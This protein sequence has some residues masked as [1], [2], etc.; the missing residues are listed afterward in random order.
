MG[1]PRILVAVSMA[2]GAIPSPAK[3][4]CAPRREGGKLGRKPKLTPHQRQEALARREAGEPLA[5]ISRSFNVSHST[6]IGFDEVLG[7]KTKFFSR[8][9]VRSRG[10]PGPPMG[11]TFP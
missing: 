11:R 6:I 1:Q 2:L 7:D 4:G 9:R 5:D 3:G 10:P 8:N